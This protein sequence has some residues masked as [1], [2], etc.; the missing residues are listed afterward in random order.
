MSLNHKLKSFL[1][2]YHYGHTDTDIRTEVTTPV[3]STCLVTALIKLCNTYERIENIKITDISPMG[4][5]T[6][7]PITNINYREVY[8]L[9]ALCSVNSPGNVVL[10]TAAHEFLIRSTGQKLEFKAMS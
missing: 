4:N 3:A 6:L 10:K 8:E 9:G 2:T 7:S 1:F 5:P